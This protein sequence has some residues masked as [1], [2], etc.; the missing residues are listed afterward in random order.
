MPKLLIEVPI[1]SMGATVNEITLIDI[2]CEAGDAVAKGD[3]IAELES[4]KSIFDFE[5]PCD[6]VIREFC[7]RA[8]DILEV[9]VPF[10]RI[11]TED[12]SMSHL[13]VDGDSASAPAKAESAAAEIAPLATVERVAT[14]AAPQ[15]AASIRSGAVRWTPRAKK[16]AIDRGLDP[17]T[18]TEIEG[19]GPGGRVTGDDLERYQASVS[20]PQ[21]SSKA[22]PAT[23][24][25]LSDQTVCVAGIGYAVPKNVRSNE[26]IL[27]EFPGKTAEEIVKV[28]GIQQRYVISEG[29]SATSLATEATHKALEMAGF[30]VAD[31]DAVIVATLLPDQPIPGAASA[32]ARELGI[33]QALAFDLNAACSGWL[34]AL[35][36]GRSFIIGGTAKNAL[37]VTAEILSSITN[38]KD[39]ETAFLF[40]D[41]AGAALLT[42]QSGGHRLYRHELSGDSRYTHAICRT[43]GGAMNP[44]PRPGDSLDAFYIQ[45]N[46]GVV[47]KRAV[48]AFAD[49]IE[50]AMKR[51]NLT[52]DEVSWIVPH[53]ANARILKAVSKRVG[54]SYEKF[55]VTVGKYGNTSAA[56][57]SMALG[58][59]AEEGIFEEDDKIIFCSVGAGF[60]YAGGLMIW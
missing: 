47:F 41:G 20:V 8:G 11:E 25:S 39:H 33:G 35:E 57:V 21:A 48:L 17:N 18:I 54:I 40:G 46:G 60:T 13:Q 43:G 36:V 30:S 56:S 50:K 31:I 10:Y 14:L 26:D 22:V 55:I 5:S 53:Q 12:E 4:D 15:K 28:T 2:L 16:L 51:H 38:A 58:W 7:C 49:I 3:K 34:Y 24:G 29:E 59:A 44:I 52:K 42:P 6:G 19:T 37:V 27:K 32:L 9:G 45:L 23:A 1:P